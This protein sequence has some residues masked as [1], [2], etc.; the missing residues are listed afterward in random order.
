M[1]YYTLHN[2]R[3]VVNEVLKMS[4]V[5][6]VLPSYNALSFSNLD[7]QLYVYAIIYYLC[8]NPYFIFII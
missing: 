5:S 7:S 8:V 2:R 6:R 4:L 3:D 1:I